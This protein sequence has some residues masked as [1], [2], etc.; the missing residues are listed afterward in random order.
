MKNIKIKLSS[1]YQTVELELDDL[2]ED[3][4]PVIDLVNRLGAS[5]DNSVDN[6][7]KNRPTERM[8]TENQIKCLER[9]GIQVD[10]SKL[11]ASQASKLL[12]NVFKNE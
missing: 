9:H 5:V 1:N 4:Q 3:L 10:P 11:T 8:A 6:K 7:P 12:D 2:N